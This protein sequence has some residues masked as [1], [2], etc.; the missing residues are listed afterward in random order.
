MCFI[1]FSL[2]VIGHGLGKAGG[3]SKTGKRNMATRHGNG[4]IFGN[5][6]ILHG[7]KCEPRNLSESTGLSPADCQQR[8]AWIHPGHPDWIHP[9]RTHLENLRGP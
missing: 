6:A 8:G 9:D 1:I 2:D 5:S 3:L 4:N 7:S